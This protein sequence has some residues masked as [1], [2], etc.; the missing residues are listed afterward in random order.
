MKITE[1]FFSVQVGDMKRA[2]AFYTGAL[3]A[4]ASFESEV[5]SSLHIA[6]VRIG[7]F[8]NPH[9]PRRIGLH[10]LVEDLDAAKAEVEQ[11]GGQVLETV[12]AA[13][14]VVLCEVLDTEGNAFTLRQA[15]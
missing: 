7:L 9:E 12:E 10:F 2:V 15:S 14:G 6:G 11:A 13:P 5:W 1:A 8:L 3:G 4:T